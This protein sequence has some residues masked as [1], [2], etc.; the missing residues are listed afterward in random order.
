MA[1]QERACA[2]SGYTRRSG[3]AS[4]SCAPQHG[5]ARASRNGEKRLGQ[6]RTACDTVGE[7]GKVD[8]IVDQ[9]QLGG[10]VEDRQVLK[11]GA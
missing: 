5:H 7:D 2:M 9:S 10:I 3:A 1:T 8:L 4:K 6:A 11:R